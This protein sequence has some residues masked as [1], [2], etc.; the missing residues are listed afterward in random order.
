MS[1]SAVQEVARE[2]I[3]TLIMVCGPAMIVALAI[4]LLISLFQALTSIQEV[5]LTFVPKI[6]LV[7]ITLLVFMPF[8]AGRMQIFMEDLFARMATPPQQELTEPGDL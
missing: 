1:P 3:I 7:F 8:M 4:G 5:T 2:A 6:I